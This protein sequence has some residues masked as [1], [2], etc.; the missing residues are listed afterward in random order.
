MIESLTG[1]IE[2]ISPLLICHT[3]AV[4]ERGELAFLAIVDEGGTFERLFL[5]RRNDGRQGKRLT[6]LCK[7]HT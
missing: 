4:A 7:S 1:V 2:E 5:E 3:D 6:W